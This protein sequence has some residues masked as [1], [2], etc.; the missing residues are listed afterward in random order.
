MLRKIEPPLFIVGLI[1]TS[2]LFRF[3][4]LFE[5]NW[6]GDEGIYQVVGRV[7]RQGGLLYR[8]AWDNKPPILYL[9]YAF[10]NGDHFLIRLLSLVFLIISIILFFLLAKKLFNKKSAIFSSTSIFAVLFSTPFLEG[11]IANAENFMLAPIILAGLLIF[12]LSARRSTLIAS[13]ILLSL[14]FLTKIVAI[15]DLAAFVIFLAFLQTWKDTEIANQLKGFAKKI[16]PLLVSF[17]LPIIVTVLFFTSKG[18]LP[19]FINST[20]SQNAGYINV[21]NKLLF[22]QGLLMIKVLL[23]AGFV[24]LLW[25]LRHLLSK[26]QMFIFLWLGFSLF[27]AFF[28]GRPYIHYLLVLLPSFALFIGEIIESKKYR[29]IYLGSLAVMILI[30]SSNFWIYG[31]TPFYY[32]NFISFVLGKKSVVSYQ[33]FFAPH[34]RRDY[35]LAQFLR[36]KLT[37]DDEIF[38]WGDNAQIYT[39]TNKL[40]PGRFTVSYHI[41]FY[42]NAY[43]ETQKAILVKKPRFIV[44]IKEIAPYE[45]LLKGYKLAFIVEGAKIYAKNPILPYK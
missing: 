32:Q 23:L 44:V 22:A 21:G 43:V 9:I 12:T 1:F 36:G 2:F 10:V 27:N 18:I 4:S 5:P 41:T 11:N 29:L 14:A 24:V 26:T 16:K 13:G 3:P 15:F 19:D 25:K 42:K 8:D 35:M 45:E 34:V 17:I 37:H 33:D 40:P 38:I 31:K 20:L 39:L 7:I 28:A 6:Y 30:I